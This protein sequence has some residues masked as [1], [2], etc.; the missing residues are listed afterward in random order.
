MKLQSKVA[1]T[2]ASFRVV[3]KK[4]PPVVGKGINH[5]VPM[6]TKKMAAH[7][8]EVVAIL[9]FAFCSLVHGPYCR[10]AITSF[11]FYF[12]CTRPIRK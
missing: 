5:V 7:D 11:C 3:R 6:S 1:R 2:S 10:N 4:I 12:T 8:E 9:H